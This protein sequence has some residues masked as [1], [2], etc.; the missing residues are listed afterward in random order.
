MQGSRVR[1]RECGRVSQRGVGQARAA[2]S[3]QRTQGERRHL[4]IDFYV[5][6]ME[7]GKHPQK[8]LLCVDQMVKELERVDRL[9]DQKD[10][11][12]VTLS[13]LTPQ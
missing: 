2:L 1:Y 13:G 11:G 9:V 6:K 7:P 8:F 10:V 4:T 3:G 5:I 12:I